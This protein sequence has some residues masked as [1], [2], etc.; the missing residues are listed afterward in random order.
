LF[1][2][3]KHLA[4]VCQDTERIEDKLRELGFDISKEVRKYLTW[5]ATKEDSKR[6]CRNWTGLLRSFPCLLEELP[7]KVRE[8]R[9][10]H[11]TQRFGAGQVYTTR[12]A[13][14]SQGAA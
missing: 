8:D 5:L 10:A 12:R 1:I 9:D 2:S 3:S 4:L 11:Y 7:R 14:R 6:N 13:G